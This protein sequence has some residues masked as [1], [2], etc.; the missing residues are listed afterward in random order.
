MILDEA[1]RLLDMGFQT[2]LTSLLELLPRQRRTG[3]F[4]ATQS[5]E[6]LD[7]ARAGLRNPVRVQVRTAPT[8]TAGAPATPKKNA[9]LTPPGT[10]GAPPA[11]LSAAQQKLGTG[12]AVRVPS[13][14]TMQASTPCPRWELGPTARCSDCVISV[15]TSHTRSTSTRA[16]TS[17]LGWLS[18]LV[19]QGITVMRQ[20]SP[21]NGR[22][23][24]MTEWVASISGVPCA[25]PGIVS[26]LP[27]L[28]A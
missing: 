21:L 20:S 24:A 5:R 4:S 6:V 3:L 10:G 28:L 26:N 7:L 13:S 18:S 9:A 2:R 19:L 15:L 23:K 22:A 11:G 17:E 16:L 1:D 12:Q 25:T 8:P 27:N 14:L